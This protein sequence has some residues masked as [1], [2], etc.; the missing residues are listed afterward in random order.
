MKNFACGGQILVTLDIR[1]HRTYFMSIAQKVKSFSYPGL[2]I[3]E[4]FTSV[5]E[6]YYSNFNAFIFLANIFL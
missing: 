3:I 5:Q 4:V 1:L 6:M 2:T